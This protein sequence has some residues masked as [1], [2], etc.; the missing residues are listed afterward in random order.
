MSRI[1]FTI[2]VD[3]PEGAQ[4]FV[5]DP[6][7]PG[8]T[9]VPPFA[10]ELIPLPDGAQA[11]PQDIQPFRGAAHAPAA[12][13]ICPV[14]REPWK[15]VPAGVSKASGKAYTAFLACPVRGCTQRPA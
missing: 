2:I 14:H 10:E 7:E 1:T 5:R 13:S 12:S 9:F 4:A 6:E 8:G 11:L 3:V 15:L